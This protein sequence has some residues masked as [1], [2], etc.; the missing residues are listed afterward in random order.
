MNE[1]WRIKYGKLV[2]DKILIFSILVGCFYRKGP[3]LSKTFQIHEGQWSCV[4]DHDLYHN[5]IIIFLGLLLPGSCHKGFVHDCKVEYSFQMKPVLKGTNILHGNKFKISKF[6]LDLL[7]TKSIGLRITGK[8]CLKYYHCRS[9]DNTVIVQ[10]FCKVQS[11]IWPWP[12]DQSSLGH[13]QLMCKV[14][15]LYVKR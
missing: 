13:D 8:T 6:D 15:L 12:I 7:T 4:L 11:R 5:N 2:S 3:A 10:K 1:A 14:S 9:N